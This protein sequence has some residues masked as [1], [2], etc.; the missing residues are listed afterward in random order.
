[1]EPSMELGVIQKYAFLLMKAEMAM[2]AT[3]AK[4]F[5]TRDQ[6]WN[7]D[8]ASFPGMASQWTDV[9]NNNIWQLPLWEG[10]NIILTDISFILVINL[11]LKHLM[12][13][14]QLSL[15]TIMVLLDSALY[16]NKEVILHTCFHT[17]WS[18]GL[19]EWWIF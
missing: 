18:I 10:Q 19:T 5:S 6:H 16:L 9:K 8:M 4:S 13:L 1:M 3:K 2:A 12:L 11:T 14:L 7:P 17:S 15:Y